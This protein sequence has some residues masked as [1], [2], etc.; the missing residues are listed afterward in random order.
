MY[1]VRVETRSLVWGPD[2][3]YQFA[4]CWGALNI[5]GVDTTSEKQSLLKATTEKIVRPEQSGLDMLRKR[6]LWLSQSVLALVLQTIPGT[7]AGSVPCAATSLVW[8]PGL[9]AKVV[10]P[11]RYFFIQA[12]DTNGRK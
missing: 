5:A 7:L 9:E 8:G 1:S 11:A 12:A 3:H 4:Q 2:V 6:L 10:L